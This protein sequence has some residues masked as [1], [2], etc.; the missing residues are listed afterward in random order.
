M[1]VNLARI[2]QQYSDYVSSN[3]AAGVPLNSMT[4][5]ILNVFQG[6]PGAKHWRRYLSEHAHK[7]GRGVDV[8]HEGLELL[9][10]HQSHDPESMPSY[11]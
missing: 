9:N 7:T 2:I 1:H 11:G 8:I 6:V 3:L 5:H 10:K 4:R